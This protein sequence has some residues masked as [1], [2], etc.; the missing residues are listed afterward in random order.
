[1][2]NDFRRTILWL[3]L[4]VSLFMLYDNWEAY[5]GRPS[6]FG[7]NQLQET[8]TEQGAQ[9]S[10]VADVPQTTGAA[11]V[12]QGIIKA[13]KPVT[14][15]SDLLKVDIDEQ[16]A[17]V[18][19]AELLKEQGTVD[20]TE[21]GIAGLVMGKKAKEPGNLVLFEVTPQHVYV[22]QTGLIGGDYPTH[23]SVFKLVSNKTEKKQDPELKK[24]VN[25][26]TV[27]F[28][29][30]Q[31]DVTLRKTFELVDG[32]YGINVVQTV[33]NNGQKAINPS[34]YYQLTRDGSKP[35][36]QP[37][38]FS[39]TF[40]GPAIYTPEDKFQKIKF[41]DIAT[42][43]N[44]NYRSNS[45]WIAMIQ[46]YFVTAWTDG[47]NS[48]GKPHE[49]YTTKLS[50]N[51]YTVGSIVKLGEIEPQKSVSID[52]MLYAG[53]QDQR[54]LEYLAPDLDL[55]V[56]YGWLT[57]LA[58]PIYNLL[59]FLHGLV[60]NWGWA[61]VLLV[62]IVKAILYPISAAGYKSM[63]RMKEMTPVMQ[64]LQKQYKD[65]KQAY[66][67]ALMDLYKKEKINPVGG[68][69]PIFLQIPIFLALY[70]VLL[71]SVELRG[72]QWLFWIHDL[73]MPDPWFILPLIMMATMFIQIK[74]NPQP[75][76][77]MQARMMILMPIVFSVMFF[78]FAS[79]LVLYWLTN[80]ILSI[81]QQWYVNKQIREERAKRLS[82]ASNGPVAKNSLFKTGKKK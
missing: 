67:R 26:T 82:S 34:V 62:I 56:D 52:S 73:S 40:T 45:G 51:L 21:V 7:V 81:A 47:T 58:K 30:T 63:A 31:S 61:I 57:F 18:T 46:H 2:G 13:D 35:E 55:V 75:A 6:F 23:K 72:S 14:L 19:K 5:N 68:C 33:I 4:A 16:G 1:M 29:S 53:P 80:N 54:R 70:W 79:G 22:A 65:D 74:L 24:E 44:H 69:L 78:F 10:K 9:P 25:V 42:S 43:P 49:F 11:A 27:V 8:Q 17:V 15:Q 66:Q 48:A 77:K 20:W 38:M 41:D 71:A 37:E 12:A 3:I 36:G 50:D 64:S 28:E 76:D 32:H 39:Y 59:Y 60:G